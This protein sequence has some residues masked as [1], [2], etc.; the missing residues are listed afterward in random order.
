MTERRYPGLISQVFQG[1]SLTL[2]KWRIQRCGRPK[3][4]IYADE[5][6]TDLLKK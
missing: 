3:K 5:Q 6:K 4:S 2:D 1:F